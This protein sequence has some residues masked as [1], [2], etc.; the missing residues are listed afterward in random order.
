[1][2]KYFELIYYFFAFVPGVTI[3]ILLFIIYLKYRNVYIGLFTGTYLATS[4]LVFYYLSNNFFANIGQS[5]QIKYSAFA[6]VV[7]MFLILWTLS[8]LI[9]KIFYERNRI[10]IKI[11]VFILSFIPVVIHSTWFFGIFG[12]K[13]VE[14]IYYLYF[15]GVLIINCILFMVKY[16]KINNKLFRKLGL[17]MASILSLFIV[18]FIAQSYI[19]GF[20]IDTFPIFYL[21]ITI[22]LINFLWKKFIENN[23][24]GVFK[25]NESFVKEYNITKREQ[26][27]IE[28]IQAGYSNAVIS[29][30]LFVSE[31]T[32]ANHIY[33]IYKKLNITSRFELICMFKK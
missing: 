5:L 2:D 11:L 31:K 15:I 6:E 14:D 18:L 28:L 13:N 20:K 8:T 26:E 33:N 25:I 23:V 1:M 24:D 16:K 22:L 17:I 10:I 4:L 32:I 9:L 19:T 21:L 12:A 27:I 3:N 7:L 30:K 29:N